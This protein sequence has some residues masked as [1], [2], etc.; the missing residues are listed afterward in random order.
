MEGKKRRKKEFTF[1][2]KPALQDSHSRPVRGKKIKAT[3]FSLHKFPSG[4]Q[5]VTDLPDV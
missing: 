1:N 4:A 2:I 5:A 3:P